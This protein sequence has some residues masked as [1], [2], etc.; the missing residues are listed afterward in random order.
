MSADVKK[1]S[2]NL[3]L[4]VAEGSYVIGSFAG[5]FESKNYP[6]KYS[7]LIKVEDTDGETTLFNKETKKE[8]EVQ[9]EEGDSVFLSESTWLA[10]IFEKMEKGTRFKLVYEGKEPPKKKGY[11]SAYKYSYEVL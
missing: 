10:N 2:P 5:R 9:I 1:K 4:R 8:E 7:T 3:D 11:K 6:G